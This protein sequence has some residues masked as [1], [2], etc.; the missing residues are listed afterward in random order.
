ES[1]LKVLPDRGAFVSLWF[2]SLKEMTKQEN[3]ERVKKGFGKHFPVRLEDK[4][5]ETIYAK[6]EKD[7]LV[8]SVQ[9]KL[10]LTEKGRKELKMLAEKQV[11]YITWPKRKFMNARKIDW[12]TEGL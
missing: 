5:Y 11:T 9:D 4:D 7:H 12:F 10:R 6:L 3:L 2:L 8:E 1:H